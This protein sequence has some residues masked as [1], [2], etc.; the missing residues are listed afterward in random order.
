MD[1]QYF[2]T[3]PVKRIICDYI[4]SMTDR[5]VL[6]LYNEIFVPTPLV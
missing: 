4:A 5:Y 3:T 2:E 1:E 6:R